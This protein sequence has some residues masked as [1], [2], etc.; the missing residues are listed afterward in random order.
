MSVRGV[1]A[2]P[3]RLGRYA[4]RAWR[5]AR[6]A[7]RKHGVS[8]WRIIREQV[9]L[10][11]QTQLRPDE[12]Y[13]FGLDDPNMP[14]E[15]KLSYISDA[16]R[17]MW[18]IMT[19]PKYHGLYRNKLLF[20]RFFGGL[21]FPVAPL[22]GVYDPACGRTADGA[23]LRN[24]EDIA[25]WM[26]STSVR[27]PVFKP[28]ES[29]EGRMVYVMKGRAPQ[30]DNAFLSIDGETYT[31]ERLAE[32]LGD[33]RLLRQAYPDEPIQRTFL[34]EKRLLPH[35]AVVS[36]TASET[37]CCARLVTLLAADG[38]VKIWATYFKVTP[39]NANADNPETGVVREGY[40]YHEHDPTPHDFHPDTGVK[41]RGARLPDWKEAVELV[42]RAALAV[43]P[44]RT[45]GWDV[46]FTPDGPYL[47][48]G[49]AAW[50]VRSVQ[51]VWRKGLNYGAFK[52]VYESRK[53]TGYANI[54]KY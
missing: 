15:D 8:P 31:P 45:I 14:W 6:P 24:A 32:T 25:A 11:R 4:W 2:L 18:Y 54:V 10:K 13:M 21:G 36:L 53:E 12:Y 19:P 41:F 50:G 47:V 38:D 40:F 46:A 34:V 37:L 33:P 28:T 22:Y 9:A 43:P 5:D 1:F 52:E 30:N 27:C 49:N 29:A 16:G 42:R 44:A 20:K 23:P 48:E 26:K 51:F 35:P 3:Y 39:G 17:R 7:A